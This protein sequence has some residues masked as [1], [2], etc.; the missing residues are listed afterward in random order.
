MK[1]LGLNKSGKYLEYAVVK[2]GVKF[3]SSGLSEISSNLTK[4]IL[5]LAKKEAISVIAIDND[6]AKKL[7]VFPATEVKVITVNPLVAGAHQSWLVFD[8]TPNFEAHF[9][10]LLWQ[11]T[12]K[13]TTINLIN[14]PEEI[15]ILDDVSQGASRLIKTLSKTME[16]NFLELAEKGNENFFIFEPVLQDNEFD[17]I[18]LNDQLKD[19]LEG[20]K[21][22][23]VSLTQAVASELKEF[24][25]YD[26]AASLHDTLINSI[27]FKLVTLGDELSVNNF[28][29]SGDLAFNPRLRKLAHDQSQLNNFNVH[30]NENEKSNPAA[31]IAGLAYFLARE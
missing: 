27:L 15:I 1:I 30:F 23:Q 14:N 31:G 28:S 8:D 9:P 11:D 26:L 25:R 13:G 6:L 21:P 29:F 12:D 22:P 7:D 4:Q 16:Q 19:A 20:Y 10:Y 18:R 2:D 3:I 24:Y 17:L 5:V